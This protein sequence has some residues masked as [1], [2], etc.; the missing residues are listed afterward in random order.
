MKTYS[1]QSSIG[2]KPERL[3][4]L[5]HG[6]GSNGKDL[7]ALAP[8]FATVLPNTLF[9]SPDAPFPCDMAP[10]MMDSYQWFSLIDRSP[11]KMLAGL[12]EAQPLLDEYLDTLLKEHD[13][14]AAKMALVGFSQGTMMSLYTAPRRH[15][16]IAG[17][18]G[19]SGAL[20]GDLS[21]ASHKPSV[22]LIHGDADDVVTVDAFHTAKTALEEAQFP[23]SGIT[24]PGLGHGIDPRGLQSGKDFLKKIL[25]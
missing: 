6:L 21:E 8:E 2:Q 18:L 7:I 20:F 24:V 19:Y 13:L 4:V 22:H 16:K 14:P 10:G 25:C 15:E 9:V 1:Y 5:L 12:K 23:F 11:N 3:V 17:V